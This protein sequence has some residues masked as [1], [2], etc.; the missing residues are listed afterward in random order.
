MDITS[1]YLFYVLSAFG[2][3]ALVFALLA[4]CTR[5]TDQKIHHQIESWKS[6]ES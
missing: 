3:T 5:K 6:D 2:I 1:S 4:F